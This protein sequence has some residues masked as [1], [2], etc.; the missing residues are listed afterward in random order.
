[1]NAI[2]PHDYKTAL[3]AINSIYESEEETLYKLECLYSGYDL[4]ASSMRTALIIGGNAQE[5]L[6]KQLDDELDQLLLDSL[7]DERNITTVSP[8]I[9]DVDLDQHLLEMSHRYADNAKSAD[10]FEAE[11]YSDIHSYE[12]LAMGINIK[13]VID[14]L[15]LKFEVTKPTTRSLI[16]KYLTEKTGTRYYISNDERDIVQDGNI[17]TMRVHDIRTKKDLQRII[18]CLE[19]YGVSFDQIKVD[20]IEVAIDFY[21]AK[22]KALL[23]ALFKSLA[24]VEGSGNERIYK[25]NVGKFI[26]IPNQPIRLLAQLEDGYCIGV[27]PNSSVIYYRLYYKMT[28]KKQNLPEQEHRL[29]AEVNCAVSVLGTDDHLSNLPEIIQSAF[30]QMKL[31][32]LNRDATEEDKKLYRDSVAMFGLRREQYYSK[33]RHKRGLS[34]VLT[35]NG[36]LNKTISKKVSNLKRNF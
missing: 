18:K 6:A 1:M 27:N 12:L 10:D 24:Y 29:R 31:T 28:D 13:T 25:N 23:I 21:G 30:G 15:D 7:A 9:S 5:I 8:Q 11:I 22:S 17:F 16:K 26:P 35:K 20:R 14:F 19:H 33:S 32:K 2:Y 4:I 34:E 36:E 3:N